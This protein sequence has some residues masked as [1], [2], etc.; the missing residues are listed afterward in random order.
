MKFLRYHSHKRLLLVL[1]FICLARFADAQYMLTYSNPGPIVPNG[2][3]LEFKLTLYPGGTFSGSYFV[4]TAPSGWTVTSATASGGTVTV[5]GDGASVRIDF[6][7]ISADTDIS[8]FIRP[9]CSILD[10]G[11]VLYEYFTASGTSLAQTTSSDISNIKFPVLVFTPPADTTFKPT[12]EAYREWNIR[13]NEPVSYVMGGDLTVKVLS[14]ASSNS[15]Y[16]RISTVELLT[17]TGWQTLPVNISSGGLGYTYTFTDADFLKIGNGDNRITSNEVIRVREKVKYDYCGT[18]GI[19]STQ[20]N[21]VYTLTHACAKT[22]LNNGESVVGYASPYPSGTGVTYIRDYRQSSPGTPG[23]FIIRLQNP[24]DIALSNIYFRYYKTMV[25]AWGFNVISCYFSDVNGVQDAS[26]PPVTATHE[27]SGTMDYIFFRF[28]STTPYKGLVALDADGI[29]NDLIK[30]SDPVYLTINW[31]MD[32]ST[33]GTCGNGGDV[34]LFS[35]RLDRGFHYTLPGCTTYQNI[36]WNDI[37]SFNM[38]F[39]NGIGSVSNPMLVI[40]KESGGLGTI[41]TLSVTDSPANTSYPNSSELNSVTAQ[42]HRIELTLPVDLVYT[43]DGVRING[44]TVDPGDVAW[45][46]ATRVLSFR[47]RIVGMTGS[48][49]YSF[50]VQAVNNMSSPRNQVTIKHT[51]DWNGTRYTYGCQTVPVS[52]RL[53]VQAPCDT[54]IGGPFR[55]ERASFGYTDR[56]MASRYQSLDAARA[57]GVNLQVV[58]P[59]DDVELEMTAYVAKDSMAIDNGLPLYADFEYQGNNTSGSGSPYFDKGR[60]ALLYYR[61]PGASAWSDAIT[62]P[63]EGVTMM[64]TGGFYTLRADIEPYLTAANVSRLAGTWF[65][66]VFLARATNNLPKTLAAVQH[67]NANLHGIGTTGLDNKNLGCDMPVSNLMLF[68]YGLMFAPLLNASDVPPEFNFWANGNSA[69]KKIVVLKLSTYNGLTGISEVFTNEFRPNAVVD[70]FSFTNDYVYNT[71]VVD[72]VYDSEG[73]TFFEGTDYTVIYSTNYYSIVFNTGLNA[74][75]DEYYRSKDVYGTDNVGDQSYYIFADVRSVCN[76]PYHYQFIGPCSYTDY[77]TSAAPVARSYASANSNYVVSVSTNADWILSTSSTQAAQ[78]TGNN[79]FSWPLRI[80]NSSTWV[81]SANG[82][83]YLMPNTYLLIEITEGSLDD[84]ELYSSVGGI[85]T[86]INIPW[87]QYNGRAGVQS[88]WIKIGNLTGEYL[89][90]SQC[91]R[92]FVLKGKYPDCVTAGTVKLRARFAVNTV[93]YPTNPYAGFTQYNRTSCYSIVPEYELTGTFLSMDFSGM[94]TEYP[95]GDIDPNK[96]KLCTPAD[97]SVS[98]INNLYAPVM[99]PELKIYRTAA[100]ALLLSD[101]ATSMSYTQNGVTV[102]YNPS[103]WSIDNSN[104]SYILVTLPSTAILNAKDTP[105]DVIT[106]TFNLIPT[107]D[108]VFGSPIYIDVYGSSLCNEREYKS[109]ATGKISLDGYDEENGPRPQLALFSITDL[110][111]IPYAGT[112]SFAVPYKNATDGKMRLKGRFALPVSTGANLTTQA[113]IQLPANMRL[114]SGGTNTF[115]KDGGGFTGTFTLNPRNRMLVVNFSDVAESTTVYYNFEVDVEAYNPQLWDCHVKT[116]TVGAMVSL[117]LKCQPTDPDYCSVGNSVLS[118]V[119]ELTLE[120]NTVEIVKNSVKFIESYDYT[121]NREKL[122][123]K[124]K[125]RNTGPD[126][127]QNAGF[128]L[129]VDNNGNQAFDT[130]DTQATGTGPILVT[131]PGMTEMDIEQDFYSI[132]SSEICKLLLVMPLADASTPPVTV[133]NPYMCTSSFDVATLTYSMPSLFR[134]CQV[135]GLQVG[136]PAIPGYTYQWSTNGQGVLTNANQSIV[137]YKYPLTAPLSGAAQTQ[138]LTLTL[139]RNGGE[140]EEDIYVS[141]YIEPKHSTWIG[142]NSTWENSVNWSN[143]LPGKCTYVVIPE[144]AMSYPLLA[145]SMND[146]DAAKCDTIEFEHSGEVARTYLLDYNAAK[147][148]LRLNPDRWYM[149]SSPLRYMYTGDYYVNGFAPNTLTWGRTP[150]VYWMYYRMGNPTTGKPYNGDLYWSMPFNV[151][152]ETMDPGKGL[153]LWADLET[154]MDTDPDPNHLKSGRSTPLDNMAH[155]TFPRSEDSYYYY[156]GIGFT[157]PNYHGSEVQGDRAKDPNNASIEWKTTLGRAGV[158]K[159]D[160]LRSRFT[161]EG[162]SDYDPATGTFTMKAWLDKPGDP[163]ALAGNPFM[164]HLS[165]NSFYTSNSSVITNSFYVWSNRSAGFFE[166]VKL[167]N[168]DMDYLT[169]SGAG[170]TIPPMQ[171]FIVVKRPDPVVF[172]TFIMNPN[173]SVINPGDK[174]RNTVTR[175]V[176]HVEMYKGDSRESAVALFYD[177]NASNLYDEAKDQYTLFPMDKSSVILYALADE[178]GEEQAVSLHTYGDLTETIPLGIHTGS[179]GDLLTFRVSGADTFDPGYSVYLEDASTKLL[180]NLRYDSTYTFTNFT[181]DINDR[182]YIRFTESAMN[183]DQQKNGDFYVYGT[184]GEVHVYS[185]ADPIEKVNVY[186]LRGQ[187]IRNNDRINSE[188]YTFDMSAYRHNAV[189]IKVQTRAG[190]KVRKL[191]IR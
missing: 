138:E 42:M 159:S 117:Q 91:K 104:D 33:V 96:Y 17:A 157:D 79:R 75:T 155:F 190:V 187:H 172:S 135:D 37:Y 34:Y 116:L 10:G 48:L 160:S 18:S 50:N 27:P 153:V 168:G 16:L 131:I 3:S 178:Y 100:G 73:R 156:N 38:G 15:A 188:Y 162:L 69:H 129:Y 191:M 93:A 173:M 32:F 80:T 125:V 105:G 20:A 183:I 65:K 98:F 130:G 127:I 67:L 76:P 112:T 56:T 19:P 139:G 182:F 154:N 167:L 78:R 113:Y 60:G 121:G 185:E 132:S 5:A 74:V 87:E 97:F 59:G 22:K 58:G 119:F 122:T 115:Y 143:G 26:A 181:G 9:G 6:A 184:N 103:T 109:I 152:D 14:N 111:N 169:T 83:D 149:L 151:M 165:L 64:Y 107:C 57:A 174:L 52:Y 114:V 170:S 62:I 84:L 150:D 180:H 55:T 36:Q 71:Q 163:T 101:P 2:G 120:K 61:L 186:N 177:E 126:E 110:G 95:N 175:S 81:T 41:T 145:K 31:N 146:P 144:D 1:L 123:V 179:R 82:A 12:M 94:V 147:V 142:S 161:Y 54:Y 30:S 4:A 102:P 158:A 77:P 118:R 166:A 141:V 70:R 92:D 68:D 99:G 88:Y 35:Q 53:Y 66:V 85:E 136:D 176:L 90:A 89:S 46:P 8:V 49:T 189:I 86:K 28:N 23:Q 47:N 171:S 134:I 124:A 40:P 72:R 44:Y 29:C 43:G 106:V 51:F 148:N 137:T 140:C 108:F 39:N 13:Q 45:D 21:L 133:N 7:S 164:S 24:N 11:K 25:D 63:P 128:Y